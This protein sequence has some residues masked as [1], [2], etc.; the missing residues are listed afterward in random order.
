MNKI[1]WTSQPMCQAIK[2]ETLTMELRFNNW[3]LEQKYY[4]WYPP[5]WDIPT[6]QASE[7][8]WRPVK[9]INLEA[10]PY[11]EKVSSQDYHSAWHAS[12]ALN[13]VIDFIKKQYQ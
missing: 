9:G 4:V 10:S 5:F 11:F 1:L 2:Q 6:P 12:R 8:E 13:N 3:V 7:E